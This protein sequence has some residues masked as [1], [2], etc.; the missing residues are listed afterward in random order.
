MDVAISVNPAKL[1]IAMAV[2]VFL[3]VITNHIMG[4]GLEK[5]WTAPKRTEKGK[6]MTDRER[7]LEIL[8]V[9]IYPHEQV[10][11]VEAVADYLL[12]NGVTFQRW[13]PVTERLP[14]K[15]LED[16]LAFDGISGFFITFMK[17]TIHGKRYFVIGH[18]DVT[19]WMPLPEPPKEK[20]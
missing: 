16:V 5:L 2:I 9:P 3:V 4:N 10:E 13:I 20:G 12:D 17:T 1:Y 15:D 11:P 19:H 8:N 6:T 14:E 18:D 7:L